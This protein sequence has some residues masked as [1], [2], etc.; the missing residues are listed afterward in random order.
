MQLEWL[1]AIPAV[2]GLGLVMGYFVRALISRRR[3]R[4]AKRSGRNAGEIQ[5]TWL[6]P[7]PAR[8]ISSESNNNALRRATDAPPI[9]ALDRE[10]AA[11]EKTTNGKASISN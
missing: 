3:R 11:L 4:R 5:V 2:F 6:E 1:A 9:L 10:F 7:P 8:R